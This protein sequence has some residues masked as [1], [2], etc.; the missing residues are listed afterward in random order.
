MSERNLVASCTL[1]IRTVSEANLREIHWARAK[2]ARQQRGLV[3]LM[4]QASPEL[5]RLVAAHGAQITL[6]RLRPK[7]RRKLDSDNC[8]IS[9]KHV[10]DGIAAVLGIDDGDERL[11]WRYQ[12]GVGAD[13]AVKVEIVPLP[14]PLPAGGGEG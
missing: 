12:Q 13:Y 11:D 2:R 8:G 10:Q 5:K 1:P 9:F 14:Q 3:S 4:M 7:G 6:T